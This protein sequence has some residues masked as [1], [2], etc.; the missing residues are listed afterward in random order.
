MLEVANMPGKMNT[1]NTEYPRP[2]FELPGWGKLLLLSTGEKFTVQ[3]IIC[4]E[5]TVNVKEM[6]FHILVWAVIEAAL[7]CSLSDLHHVTATFS[8]TI[9]QNLDLQHAVAFQLGQNSKLPNCGFTFWP[10]HAHPTDVAQ[11]VVK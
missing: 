1:L 5:E 4:L 3:G 8:S 9:P 6:N 11:M 7:H 10:A 2:L